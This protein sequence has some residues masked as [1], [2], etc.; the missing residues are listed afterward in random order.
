MPVI[1]A[2]LGVGLASSLAFRAIIVAEHIAP[3]WVRP[4]WYAAVLLNAA[5]FSYRYWVSRRRVRAVLAGDLDGKLYRGEP[6]AG[7]ERA[8]A[9]AIL[10]SIRISPERWNY[11]VIFFLSAAAIAADLWLGA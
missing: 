7:D 4:L 10:H 8:Q 3:D 1:V 6:L 5:F 11:L 9:A 2:L